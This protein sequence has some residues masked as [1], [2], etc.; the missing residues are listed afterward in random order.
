MCKLFTRVDTFHTCEHNAVVSEC[1]IGVTHFEFTHSSR[2]C[3][4]PGYTLAVY[5]PSGKQGL[6][7]KGVQVR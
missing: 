4:S 5:T 1:V 7:F 3:N 2:V 6:S